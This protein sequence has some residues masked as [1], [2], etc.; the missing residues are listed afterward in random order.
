MEIPYYEVAQ[1]HWQT[2]IH[3]SEE[4]GSHLRA[5]KFVNVSVSAAEG[6]VIDAVEAHA[7]KKLRFT[8]I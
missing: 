3:V 4:A 6:G 2:R 7:I 1:R 5:P 8:K